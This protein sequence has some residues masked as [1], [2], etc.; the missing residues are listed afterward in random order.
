MKLLPLSYLVKFEIFVEKLYVIKNNL[1]H[2]KRG[3]LKKGEKKNFIF[4]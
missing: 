3:L 4:F 1:F 2:I